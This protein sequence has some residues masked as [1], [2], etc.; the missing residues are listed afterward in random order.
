[1][2][3]SAP[4]A[5]PFTRDV[6]RLYFDMFADD[7]LA[8]AFDRPTLMRHQGLLHI[9]FHISCVSLPDLRGHISPTAS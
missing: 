9:V 3:E 2:I 5:A 1:M 4:L 7:R 6:R 8:K